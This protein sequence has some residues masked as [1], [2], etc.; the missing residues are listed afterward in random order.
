M[1]LWLAAE[2]ARAGLAQ[3]RAADAARRPPAFRSSCVRPIST[4][5]AW[6]QMQR[7]RRPLQSLHSWRA[8]RH[9]FVSRSQPGRLVLGADQTLALGT[10]RF[11]KPADRA[12]ARAQLR[13]LCGRTHELHSAIAFV[14]DETVLFEHVEMARLTMRSFSDRFLELYLDTVGSAATASVG[15]YQVEGLGIQLFERDRG[16]LFHRSRIAAHGGTRFSA[17]TRVSRSMSGERPFVLCLTGSLGMGKSRT[18]TFFAEAGVPVHDSD[19]A[20]HALYEGEAVPLIE[21][22][23][24]G[25]TAGGKVDRAQACS[26]GARQRCGA[27]QA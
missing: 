1:A 4:S 9:L 26:D 8:K 15:A 14:Q 21:S 6:K 24:P 11:A 27:R 10:K 25:A 19:A 12:A 16:R 20:V 17:A 2:S 18:A 13:V 5:A 7:R 23:F 22:A 3:R